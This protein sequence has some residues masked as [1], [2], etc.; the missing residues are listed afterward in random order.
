MVRGGGESRE[1][2]PQ[3]LTFWLQGGVGEGDRVSYGGGLSLVSNFRRFLDRSAELADRVTKK[4][5]SCAQLDS[6]GS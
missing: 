2:Y 3:G 6:R 5:L 1:R 4:V